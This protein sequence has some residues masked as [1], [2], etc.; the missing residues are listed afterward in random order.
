MSE[1][2]VDIFDDCLVHECSIP[3]TCLFVWKFAMSVTL[4]ET[5]VGDPLRHKSLSVFPLF[6]NSDGK[7]DYRLSEAAFADESLLVEEVNQGGSVSELLVENKGDVRVL[8]LEG[9]EFVG[10]KQNRIV[11]TSLLVPPHSKIKIPVS[12]V[13]QGRWRYTSKYFRSSG[14]HSPS[15]LKRALKASVSKALKEKRGHKSDQHQVWQRV[16]DIHAYYDMSPET[17][18]MADAFDAN[19]E[20]IEAYRSELQYV[21]KAS[22]IAVAIG[23]EVISVDIFDQPAT[24][25]QVWTRMLSGVVLDAIEAGEIDQRASIADVEQLIATAV[26]LPWSQTE[27]IGEGEEYR[28][29]ADEGDQASA[30]VLDATVVHGNVMAKA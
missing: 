26:D 9:E 17:G 1:K 15:K 23:D 20:K 6:S 5:R 7:V 16:E 30:L 12:C 2:V 13:E 3:V 4:P 24:C 27:A 29:S 22:G 18:A 8:L 11:N 10:A 19:Q 25:Q 14:S 21:E 28:A